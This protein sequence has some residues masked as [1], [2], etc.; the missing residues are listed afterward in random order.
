MEQT[1][2]VVAA[3]ALIALAILA[4]S[5][6]GVRADLRARQQ[7]FNAEL[8]RVRDEQ[9]SIASRE[10]AVQ[11]EEWKREAEAEL[12]QDAI[13]RSQSVIVG[14][15]TEHLTP[16]LPEFDWNPK[17]A[18]FIGTPV[19]FLVF[20]GLDEGAVREVVF[21]EVKTGASTLTRREQAV[22]DAVEAGRVSWRAIRV[23]RDGNAPV[24]DQLHS[25]W[26]QDLWKRVTT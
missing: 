9:W 23:T 8:A 18:R 7:T 3:A 21:V 19:D 11:L 2:L 24:R 12:R 6:A 4:W 22:R 16:Y 17:D 25:S 1:A 20:D 14:K 13:K 5:Y 26:W 15:V 10:A